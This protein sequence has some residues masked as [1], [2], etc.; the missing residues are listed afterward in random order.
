MTL[1]EKVNQNRIC[2]QNDI[3]S[4]DSTSIVQKYILQG[5]PIV[6]SSDRYFRLR[7]AISGKF[8]L[9]PNDILLVGSAK[10]GFSL[11]ENRMLENFCNESDI[12]VAIVSAGLFQ[13]VWQEAF[14]YRDSVGNWSNFPSFRRYLF[15][16]WIRPDFLPLSE[17]FE[18]AEEWNSFF[19]QLTASGEFG[20][21]KI[22]AGLYHSL[23]FLESYHCKCIEMCVAALGE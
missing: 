3:F 6:L 17:N 10:L 22:A 18:F 12:D 23:F 2:F 5:E 11:S 9:H 4:E 21:Y 7:K 14:K 19:Q 15:K 1:S 8:G 13:R 20:P 16:G